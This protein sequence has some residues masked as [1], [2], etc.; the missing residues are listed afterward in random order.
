MT[1][2]NRKIIEFKPVEIEPG[3]QLN[4]D[5]DSKKMQ[6]KTVDVDIYLAW[7]FGRYHFANERLENIMRV[8]SRW[9]DYDIIYKNEIVK[10]INYT[11][12]IKKVDNI[13]DLLNALEHIDGVSFELKDKEI[14]VK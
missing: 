3:Q 4:I 7:M 14:V 8:L 11:G 13:E 12:Q 2:A 9:Y 5:F 1:T 6:L 10:N